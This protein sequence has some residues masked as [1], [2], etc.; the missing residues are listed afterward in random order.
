V[1][2]KIVRKEKAVFTKHIKIT[3]KM[4]KPCIELCDAINSIPGLQTT[5]S[6][7]G[8]SKKSFEIGLVAKTVDDLYPLTKC[9]DFFI[10][11]TWDWKLSTVHIIEVCIPWDNPDKL[12]VGF[13]LHS[14]KSVGRKAYVQSRKIAEVLRD[15]RKRNSY[16]FE[17]N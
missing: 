4:D 16:V 8:H 1:E 17:K 5:Y 11:K 12:K 2:Q 6:C 15:K 9:I 13:I 10:L 3:G 14:G 7:C